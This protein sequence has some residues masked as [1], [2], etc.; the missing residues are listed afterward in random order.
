MERRKYRAAIIGCGRIA[1][2]FDDDPMMVKTFGITT[3]AGAYTNNPN[4]ELIAASDISEEKLKTFGKR[5]SVKNLYSDYK[6]LFKKEEIDIVSI[7]TW[8]SI[9]LDIMEI[10][11]KN[12]VKAVW[13]EKPISDSLLNAEKMIDIAENNDILLV[14]NH[15]RRWDTLYQEIG[16]FINNGELGDIQQVSCYYTGGL[17]NTCS[18]LFDVLRMF[19]GDVGSVASWL[20][21]N[22]SENDPNMDGYLRFNNGTT[23]T[24]QSV[25]PKSYLIFEFDIYGTNGRLRIQDNGFN[26]S[27]WKAIESLKY[28]GF[29]EL[30]V[31]TPPFKIQSKNMMK[32]AVSNIVE[33]LEMGKE[34]ACSGIDGLKS[35]EVISGFIESSRDNNIPVSFPLKNRNI[36]I[37]SN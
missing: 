5:W 17:V 19:F 8:N 21:D 36:T 1:S 28:K 26:L 2:A 32:N 4:I 3:H 10:A 12:N 24:L 33:C 25:T 23:A 9:H 13:C 30:S 27:Y 16:K 15:N 22:A 20:K 35:L 34:P 6:E 14:I 7:C 18:H 31:E 11:A 37:N 29:K